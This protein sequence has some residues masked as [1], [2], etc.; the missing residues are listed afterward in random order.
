M[1]FPLALLQAWHELD[2]NLGSPEDMEAFPWSGPVAMVI[3]LLLGF[4]L[5]KG[6]RNYLALPELPVIKNAPPAD[7]TVVIPARNEEASIR[8]CV[9]GFPNVRVLVVDDDSSDQ[10]AAVA[11]AAGAEV[12]AAP[13]LPKGAMGKPNA[14]AAG[15]KLATTAYVFFTEAR[16]RFQPEFLP[17]AAGYAEKHQCVLLSAFLKQDCKTWLEKMLIPYAFGLYFTGVNASRLQNVLAAE[18]LAYGP[19]MLFQR[20]A[21][22]FFGGYPS[23]QTSQIEDIAIAQKVKRHRMKI[24]IMRA[25]RLG[26]VRMYDSLASLRRGLR[27]RAWRFL[28]LN[29]SGGWQVMLTSLL[30]LSI[31]PFALWLIRQQQ[32]HFLA[33]FLMAPP[34]FFK[35]WYGSYARALLFYLPAIYVFQILAL[36]GIAAGILGLRTSWK[37][38]SV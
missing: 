20:S 15:E 5:W 11:S 38:R 17:L 30:L 16:A 31:G 4:L 6:R 28:G 3:L 33:V 23:V 21:Y 2:F 27:R 7:V 35:P 29:R 32:W 18:T 25:E 37:G 24:S 10:T 34:L 22:E 36:E 8:Q 26:A 12:I 13:E 1:T 9:L 14:M 19:C